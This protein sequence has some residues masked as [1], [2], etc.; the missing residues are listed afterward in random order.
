MYKQL[1]QNFIQTT[2][3]S[4]LWF[5]FLASLIFYN[6]TVPFNFLW[7]IIG[8]GL[9]F[10]ITFG[11]VY[12]YFWKYATT[13]ATTNIILSTIINLLCGLLGVYLF[14]T[15]MFSLITPYIWLVTLLTLI[16]HIIAFY[17]YSKHENKQQVKKLNQL[18][19]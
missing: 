3:G 16:G 11:L 4:I 2:L 17:F 13:G 18:L 6:K 7:H 19:S 10:G 15:E 5:S 1:K 8:I 9:L 14:S 12:P